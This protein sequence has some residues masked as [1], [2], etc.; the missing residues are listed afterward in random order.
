MYNNGFS[1]DGLTERDIDRLIA[2]A[3]DSADQAAAA[4]TSALLD[5]TAARRR[6]R[7]MERRV[8]NGTVRALPVR[9]F[10][11]DPD[12]QEAA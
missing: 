10:L 8:V 3:Y 5:G 12:G 6:T 7:R 11:T 9:Q 4:P 2:D 1:P